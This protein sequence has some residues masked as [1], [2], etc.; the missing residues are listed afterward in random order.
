M[1]RSAIARLSALV[2]T[3]AVAWLAAPAFAAAVARVQL[4]HTSAGTI[5]VNG[6]GFTLYS[7]TRDPRNRDRCASTSGCASIW[8]LLRTNGKPIAGKGVEHRLLGSIRVGHSRQ[9]TY[10]GHPLYTY[11]ADPGPGST[12]YVGFEQFGGKWFALNANGKVVR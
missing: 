5:L 7:F 6:K 12:D 10:A 2:M 4:R 9:V 8:Q 1:K 11:I 3:V